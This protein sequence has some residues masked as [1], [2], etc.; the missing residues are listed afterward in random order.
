M[1]GTKL[2]MTVEHGQDVY[3]CELRDLDA[4]GIECH[5]SLNGVLLQTRRFTTA[6]LA[7]HWA[8]EKRRAILAAT[9]EW[10]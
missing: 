7:V 10:S 1:N 8:E 9:V 6:L 3:R 5:W 2:L 4:H